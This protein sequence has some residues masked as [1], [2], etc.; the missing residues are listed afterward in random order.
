MFDLVPLKRSL[1]LQEKW[2]C[3]DLDTH[4]FKFFTLPNALHLCRHC[5]KLKQLRYIIIKFVN[6]SATTN[7]LDMLFVFDCH[8]WQVKHFFVE[9]I[10]FY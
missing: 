8:A 5:V 1:Q 4:I 3:G 10:R 6:L 7:A 2:L 9:I